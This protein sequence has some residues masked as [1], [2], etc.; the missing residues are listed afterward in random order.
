MK[1]VV[2]VDL[3]TQS[4]KVIFYDFAARE[5]VASASASLQMYQDD[6]GAAEQDA[7]WWLDA[8]HEALAKVDAA[9]RG[10]AA[11]VGVSGQQHGFVPLGRAGEVLAPVKLWCD[12][13]TVAECDEIMEAY[14]GAQKCLQ[15]VGNLVLPGYTASKLRWLKKE[16]QDLYGQLDCILLPHDYLNY[17]LTG[18]RCMEAGDASGTG[19]LDIRERSWSRRM[20]HAID[21]DR[22]LAECLPPLYR[23]TRAVGALSRAAARQTGLPAGVPVSSGGGDNM[24]G[25]IGTGNVRAGKLTMSLG[26]SGTVY[27]Y[28]DR[29]VI[30][31]EG[32]IAAYCS[33]NGG[34]LPLM[35][36]MNC[37]VTTELMR[38]L[39]GADIRAFEALVGQSRPGAEGVITLPFFNGERTPNLP[40]AKACILGLDSH[41]TR[42]ENLLR[43]AVEGATFALRYGMGRLRDL[44]I[45]A[46]EIL[47][48]GGGA[49]SATWR[50]VVADVCGAPV[51]LLKQDEAACFGA[52]L[53]ALCVLD[54]GGDGDLSALVDEHMARNEDMYCEPEQSAVNFYDEA[55]GRYQDAVRAI[56]PLYNS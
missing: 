8:L 2:G 51:A 39:L 43:S 34:W 46:G 28:S 25:A 9:V 27:A 23:S 10:S 31:T 36:T 21:P 13:S 32:E 16:R 44:G 40:R 15:E 6:R 50:Q 47:L 7:R 12:T 22:D 19:F 18:E 48:A 55:Y 35:C 4:L 14:G 37:T 33:S 11:A 52:A 30:D 17:Y 49:R 1:T 53:Q 29:P 5:I 24:M 42:P 3:G 54:G 38:Q 20:L 41:N 56:T 45:E 26:T